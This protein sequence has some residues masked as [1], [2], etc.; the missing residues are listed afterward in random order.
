MVWGAWPLAEMTWP[1]YGAWPAGSSR[2]AVR[3]APCGCVVGNLV[4]IS[5][6]HTGETQAVSWHWPL[7]VAQPALSAHLD[8]MCW[9]EEEEEGVLVERSELA[10]IASS[11]VAETQPRI[12][13]MQKRP[14]LWVNPTDR[15]W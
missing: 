4:L 1:S 10:E 9:Q 6:A 12:Q 3:G 5:L 11:R 8:R 7:A 13:G 14:G 2:C 15:R